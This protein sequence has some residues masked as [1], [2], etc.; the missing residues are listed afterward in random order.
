MA[1][2]L[3]HIHKKLSHLTYKSKLLHH[4]FQTSS[5]LFKDVQTWS[6]D[7][8]IHPN[9]FITIFKQVQTCLKDD[10]IMQKQE[11]RKAK[12]NPKNRANVIRPLC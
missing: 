2:K 11:L 5:N 8:A 3:S 4:Y 9:Y 6:K 7:D 12:K 1:Q 10:A